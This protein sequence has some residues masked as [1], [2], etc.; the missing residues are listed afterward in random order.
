MDEEKK[1]SGPDLKAGIEWSKLAENQPFPGH[2]EGEQVV[3]VR[4]GDRVFALAAGCTHYGGPLAEG[5][6][7]D[8]TIRCP[9]HH[10]RF[11]LRTGEAEGA[12]ALNPVACYHV[13]REGNRVAIAG[14]KESDFRVSCPLNPSSVVIVGAGAAGGACAEMLR[15]KGYS[16]PVTLVAEEQP[17]PV[18]RPNLSKDY[19]AGTAPEE[20]IPLRGPEYYQSIQVDMVAG[21]PAAR[22]LPQ[23]RQVVLQDGRAISY[24][25]LLLATG[26]EPRLLPIEGANLPH[27]HRLRTLADSKAIIANSDQV[28]KCVVIGSSFIGLEVAASLRARQREVTVIGQDAIPLEKILGL[29]VGRFV[30]KLH[31][32]HG[33]RFLLGTTPRAILPDRVEV[34]KGPAVEAHLVVLGVGVSPRTSLAEQAGI[35]VGNGVVVDNT[36]RTNVPGIFAAGDIAR[37]PEPLS[38][39]PARIEHWVVA[40]RQGQAAARAMLGIGG[41]YRQTPFFW[42]QHYDVQISYVGHAST[43]DSCEIDGDLESHNA[44]AIYRRKDRILAVATI[45]RDQTSLRVEAAMEAGDQAG[46]EA[47]LR[48]RG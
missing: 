32:Q 25:A 15:T 20:W 14:K 10:A 5:L 17:S 33:V 43:W 38:G 41:P 36:L 7:V 46:V 47:A 11:D 23:E 44:C 8:N 26:A 30:Q 22:I 28:Q 29:D 27:V 16:G 12:P 48:F 19:L 9:W 42:S 18:D 1:L 24:G 6:V 3:L 31:E 13:M 40:Q 4:Q 39:E 21:N 45:G 35:K 37:Y 2:Y 34:D